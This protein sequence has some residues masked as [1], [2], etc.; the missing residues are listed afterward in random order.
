MCKLCDDGG[1]HGYEPAES[2]SAL[3]D[4]LEDIKREQKQIKAVATIVISSAWFIVTFA[5]GKFVSLLVGDLAIFA[6]G[7][8]FMI[9]VIPKSSNDRTVGPRFSAVPHE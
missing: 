7:M 3:T 6:A 1:E 4:G 8:V 2:Q 5:V 9:I